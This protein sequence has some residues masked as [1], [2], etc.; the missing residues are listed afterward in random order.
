MS[1]RRRRRDRVVSS[2]KPGATEFDVATS[3]DVPRFAYRD[4]EADDGY[5][6]HNAVY[7]ERVQRGTGRRYGVPP[8]VDIPPLYR[9]AA[10]PRTPRLRNGP[11]WRLFVRVPYR[12]RFCVK[13]KQRKQVLFA[14]GVAGRRGIGRGKRWIRNSTSSYRC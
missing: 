1:F 5:L 11:S 10:L 14:Y 12:E 3:Q 7:L 8:I 6:P 9:R 4:F 2:S 13:R